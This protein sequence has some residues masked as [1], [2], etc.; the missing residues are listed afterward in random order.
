MQGGPRRAPVST[1][2]LHHDA[3]LAAAEVGQTCVVIWRG[4]VTAVPF[5]RQRTAFDEVM[6][7]HPDGAA[8]L[9]LVER[10]AK[11]P[12]DELRRASLKMILNHV[13]RLRCV[14]C[15]IEGDGFVASINRSALSA[16]MLLAGPQK[17]PFAVFAKMGEAAIWMRR[18]LDIGSTDGF[19]SAV[20]H[21]RSYLI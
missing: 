12:G 9:C 2:L 17:T 20:E 16:M 4:E 10:T 14:A 8:F 19:I 11:A 6:G 18:Y 5:E 3:T 7:A 1:R 15:V 13:D 21:V